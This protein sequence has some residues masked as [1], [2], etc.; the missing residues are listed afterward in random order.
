MHKILVKLYFDKIME[1]KM[2]DS[3]KK[4]IIEKIKKTGKIPLPYKSLLRS[5][6]VPHGEF[7]D[8]TKMLEGLK[9]KGEIIEQKDGFIMPKHSTFVTAKVVKL[10]KSS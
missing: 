9:Q 8:F 5:C 2:K 7:Q 6:R 4:I 1:D 3:Y 10:N